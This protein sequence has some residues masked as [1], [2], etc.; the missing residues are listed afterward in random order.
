MGQ[1][2]RARDTKLNLDVAL[3]VLP[4]SFARDAERLARFTREAQTP[5]ALNHPNIAHVRGLEE[6]QIARA[7]V[8]AFV[9]GEDLARRVPCSRRDAEKPQPAEARRPS[10]AGTADA[11]SRSS[12]IPL[13]VPPGSCR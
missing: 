4:D 8:M 11:S 13:T 2:Y 3:E 10:A 5:A 1:V 9:E 6:S 12:A 7:L